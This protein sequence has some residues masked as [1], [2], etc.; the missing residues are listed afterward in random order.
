MSLTITGI[1]HIAM[2]VPEL[3]P[4][5]ALFRDLFGFRPAERWTAGDAQGVRFAVPG[6][7]GMRWEVLAPREAPSAGFLDGFLEG[8][9]GPGV[10]HVALRVGDLAAAGESLRAAGV[11]VERVGERL[12]IPA[13]GDGQG[14]TFYLGAGEGAACGSPAAADGGAAAAADDAADGAT[15][16]GASGAETLGVVSIDH[17]CHAHAD[18]D[19]LGGWYEQVFG[20]RQVFRT[21]PG[22]HEDLADLVLAVPGGQVTW[23]VLQPVGEGSFVER[24]LDR[25]GPSVHHVAF[26]VQDWAQAVA[27]CERHG[28]SFF[29]ESDGETDGAAWR[30]A[31]IHPR[32]TGGLLVQC[33]WEERPGAWVASDKVPVGAG[34]GPGG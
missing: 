18:R 10:H 28:V 21:P 20:M 30:D 33:F 2:A 34:A 9:R 26:E 17:L 6:V 27:A 16:G 24:F 19:Q 23:E 4:Q 3:P 8:P 15:D 32:E 5:E 25:R 12:C 11:G 7:G 22:R 14:L 31:F 29:D 1:D 13:A